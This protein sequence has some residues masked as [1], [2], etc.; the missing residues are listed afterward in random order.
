[1]KKIISTIAVASLCL[2]STASAFTTSELDALALILGIDTSTDT[3]ALVLANAEE[4]EMSEGTSGVTEGQFVISGQKFNDL[5][6]NGWR[7][8][9]EPAVAGV[10]ICTTSAAPGVV[11]SIC[12]TTDQNGSYIHGVDFDSF[13]TYDTSASSTAVDSLCTVENAQPGVEYYCDFGNT[14]VEV[15]EP[16]PEPEP[17][18]T[19]E[20]PV[21][22]SGQKFNDLNGNGEID[23]GEPALAGVE[24]CGLNLRTNEEHCTFTDENGGYIMHDVSLD[25]CIIYEKNIP[26]GW[27]QTAPA[28][29]ECL[30]ENPQPGVE[31]YCDFGNTQVEV[32]PEPPTYGNGSGDVVRRDGR[33]GPRRWWSRGNRS[34]EVAHSGAPRRWW[35]R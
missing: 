26:Q 11:A 22:V 16:E 31:Y 1:M 21:K 17:P 13:F 6:G 3:W 9:G 35:R 15:V 33:R 20:Y 12:S 25:D 10:D 5:N 4:D 24:I 8:E 2:V 28:G 18:V 30:I 14:Q 27:E 7:E 34:N 29:G 19:G 23:A 32:G